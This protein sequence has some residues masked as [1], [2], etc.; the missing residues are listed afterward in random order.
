MRFP[1][2]PDMELVLN[3]ELDEYLDPESGAG[4]VVTLHEDGTFPHILAHGVHVYAD[5]TYSLA[6]EKVYITTIQPP[7]IHSSHSPNSLMYHTS[8]SFINIIRVV[9]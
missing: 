4:L 5:H 7:F 3:A 6:V 9:R 8:I 2:L 1:S